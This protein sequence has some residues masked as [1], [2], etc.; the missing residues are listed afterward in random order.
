MRILSENFKWKFKNWDFEG[1][2]GVQDLIQNHFKLQFAK[3]Q[4]A[5]LQFAKKHTHP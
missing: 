2:Q 4:I 5:K 1:V 3:K